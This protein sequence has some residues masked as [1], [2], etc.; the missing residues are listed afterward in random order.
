MA[1]L[2]RLVVP[3]LP[4]HVIHR[5][6]NRQPIF[7]DDSDRSVFLE[8][9]SNASALNEVP[10]HAYVLMPNHVHLLLTPATELALARL[11]QQLARRYAQRF[12][13]RHGRTGGLFEGRF[14]SSVVQTDHYGLACIRY[15]ELNP[16]R[17]GLAHDP[18]AFRWSSHRHHA[19][20]QRNPLI[21]EHPVYWSLGNTPFEREQ[22]F[23]RLFDDPGLAEMEQIRGA[24]H[25]GWAVGTDKW[26]NDLATGAAR[27][28]ARLPRGRKPVLSNMSPI[29]GVSLPEKN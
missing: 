4:H 22:A 28:A 5:G 12:N 29:A 20:L 1:R 27:R 9:L 25:G 13:L 19:G 16:V 6:N 21:T 17:A 23:R 18:T 11:M 15:I 2:A 14:R 8:Y 24:I 3:G 10:V 26:K 7:I